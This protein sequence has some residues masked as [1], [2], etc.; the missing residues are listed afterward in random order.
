[1]AWSQHATERPAP[2]RCSGRPSTGMS[3]A[4]GSKARG[5][6]GWNE[7]PAGMRT[8]LL[9]SLGSAA[10]T[11]LSIYGFEPAAGSPESTDTSRVAAQIV[12][13]IGFRL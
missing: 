1:M 2:S 4:H 11:V 9:V 7:H 10:F 3:V 8:H 6:R 5:Q 12:T 13:G